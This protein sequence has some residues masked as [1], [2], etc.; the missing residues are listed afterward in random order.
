MPALPPRFTSCPLP[1]ALLALPARPPAL[2]LTYFRRTS[3]LPP[4]SGPGIA[5][6]R[7]RP[8]RPRDP[9]FTGRLS[10]TPPP[11]GGP[12]GLAAAT[13][14]AVSFPGWRGS[15]SSLPG[16]GG[17]GVCRYNGLRPKPRGSRGW[18]GARG[19]TPPPY[20][21][22]CPWGAIWE[23]LEQ[24]GPCWRPLAAVCVDLYLTAAEG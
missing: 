5:L 8:G 22:G 7:F 21:V 4:F 23:L 24:A 10:P 2:R 20:S 17:G 9:S 15:F 3:V 12:P 16:L 6:W 14:G 1:L 19:L 11:S 13:C 18:Y